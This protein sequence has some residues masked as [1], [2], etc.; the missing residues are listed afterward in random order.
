MSVEADE[1]T[2][3]E[4][5]A[6]FYDD[7]E[8][9]LLMR[10]Q[11]HNLPMMERQRLWLLKKDF[12]VRLSCSNLCTSIHLMHNAVQK[13]RGKDELLADPI[14]QDLSPRAWNSRDSWE[15]AKVGDLTG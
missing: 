9:Q 2:A 4:I 6:K 1:H 15:K 10:G 11:W 13:E 7:L 5:D 12:H 8:S 14:L 3:V